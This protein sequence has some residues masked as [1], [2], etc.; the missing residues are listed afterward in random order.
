MF[1]F[2][3]AEVDRSFTL[4]LKMTGVV[5]EFRNEILQNGSD[6][7]PYVITSHSFR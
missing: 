2:I 4:Q 5:S 7:K 3:K 1:L 6:A